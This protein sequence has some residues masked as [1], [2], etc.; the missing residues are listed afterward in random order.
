MVFLVAFG[1]SAQAQTRGNFRRVVATDSSL[2]LGDKTLSNS[3]FSQ[4]GLTPF[5]PF[6]VTASVSFRRKA[7]RQPSRTLPVPLTSALLRAK[8]NL[9]P[10]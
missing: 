10:P 8:F 1:L 6:Q 9:H 3:S 5:G 4:T 2:S 7:I